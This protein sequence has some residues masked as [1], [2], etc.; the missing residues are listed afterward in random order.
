MPDTKYSDNHY[1]EEFSGVKNYFQ[2][3]KKAIKEMY[4]QVGDLRVNSKGIARKGL[5]IRHLV[6]PGGLYGLS[7]SKKILDFIAYDISKDTYIN[8]MGQYHPAS[9]SY[10]YPDTIG[11]K[12]LRSHYHEVRDYA[13]SIG[14]HRGLS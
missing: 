12:L 5:L 13:Q 4:R 11:R 10:N 9:S 8:I 1:A 3:L 2:V 14:L 7:G 6:M